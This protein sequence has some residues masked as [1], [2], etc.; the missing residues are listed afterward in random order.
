MFDEKIENLLTMVTQIVHDPRHVW[1]FEV[2]LPGL[3]ED[4]SCE[5]INGSVPCWKIFA[6]NLRHIKR[7]AFSG[8]KMSHHF[9]NSIGPFVKI[10][11]A[12]G[13]IYPYSLGKVWDLVNET[14]GS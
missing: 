9:G 5:Y 7:D 6:D 13:V 14:V 12:K 11:K 2:V 4:R 1:I 10:E 3:C 8:N